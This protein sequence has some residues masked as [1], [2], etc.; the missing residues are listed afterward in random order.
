MLIPFISNRLLCS[1]SLKE[2][3]KLSWKGVRIF[4]SSLNQEGNI[5]VKAMSKDLRA[6]GSWL[7]IPQISHK[8]NRINTIPFLEILG[9]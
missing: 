3:G 2:Q 8:C 1:D 4:Y 7:R 9:Q 6:G 5:G